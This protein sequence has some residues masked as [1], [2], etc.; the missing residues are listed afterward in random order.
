MLTDEQRK[1]IEDNHN[2]IYSFLH[3]YDYDPEEYYGLAAIGLCRAAKLYDV[4]KGS[5]STY[6]Y[7]AMRGCVINDI[8]ERSAA[9]RI[10][11]NLI[12]SYNNDICTEDGGIVEYLDTLTSNEDLEKEVVEK[13]LVESCMAKL[14]DRD[15]LIFNLLI[16]GYD[17]REIAKIVGVCWRTVSRTKER[18]ILKMMCELI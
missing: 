10:P 11:E 12:D 1:L 3:K 9:K 15:R 8:R 5:F 16:K 14:S 4:S 6:A 2:L 18:I 7:R 17:Y 13:V